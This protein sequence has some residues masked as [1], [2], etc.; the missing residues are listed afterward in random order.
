MMEHNADAFMSTAD[1]AKLLFVSRPHIVKLVEQGKLELHHVTGQTRFVKTESVLAYQK[2]RQ[3]AT[4][5][6]QSTAG[7][8]E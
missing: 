1:A 5:A 7:Q 6:Y 2:A 8:E 4:A 3:T